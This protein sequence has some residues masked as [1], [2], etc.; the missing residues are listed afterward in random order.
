MATAR[1]LGME[2]GDSA[3]LEGRPRRLDDLAA[4]GLRAMLG[5]LL[6]SY[7]TGTIA[8]LLLP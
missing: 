3:A 8:G 6:A 2:G 1:T 5:G 7:L 4:L